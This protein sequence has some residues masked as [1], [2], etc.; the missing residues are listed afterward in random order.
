M[1][2]LNELWE[3]LTKFIGSF[4]M[5]VLLIAGVMLYAGLVKVDC[6]THGMCVLYL[7]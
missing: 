7:R 2:L 6:N 4:A 3:E 1:K 5:S